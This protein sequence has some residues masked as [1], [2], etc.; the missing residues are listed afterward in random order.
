MGLRQQKHRSRGTTIWPTLGRLAFSSP[1][2]MC[3]ALV[4]V[5]VIA[6]CLEPFFG[7]PEFRLVQHQ[8]LERDYVGFS[9]GDYTFSNVE[10]GFVTSSEY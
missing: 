1:R 4:I 9:L 6:A 2:L 5:P 10:T 3:D 7:I 8:L